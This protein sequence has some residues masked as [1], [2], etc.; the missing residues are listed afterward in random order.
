MHTA[1]LAIEIDDLAIMTR[2]VDDQSF[3]DS[4]AHETRARASRN[5]RQ[6]NIG[7]G[8]N[9]RACLVRVTGESRADRLDLINGGI[10]RV[11]LSRQIIKPSVAPGLLDFSLLRGSHFDCS[12]ITRA[13]SI[14]KCALASVR[15]A[16]PIRAR[17]TLT[18]AAVK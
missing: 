2:E 4:V 1:V 5:N 14:K 10:G 11:K 12:N 18:C 9:H 17:Q 16:H 6:V 13:R 3:A 7:C 15:P 8:T